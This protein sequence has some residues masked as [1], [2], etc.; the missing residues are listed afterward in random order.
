MQAAKAKCDKEQQGLYSEINSVLKQVGDL[1]VQA[2][3]D[4]NMK[5]TA[6]KEVVKTASDQ[7]KSLQEKIKAGNEELA[8]SNPAAAAS[9]KA[10]MAS[11]VGKIGAMNKGVKAASAAAAAKQTMQDAMGIM[12][13]A[14]T[15]AEVKDSL[16]YICSLISAK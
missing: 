2:D 12:N 10:K 1:S 16:S 8:V 6:V 9:G 7:I 14:T 3:Q 13:N 4:V 5:L 11:A 15:V